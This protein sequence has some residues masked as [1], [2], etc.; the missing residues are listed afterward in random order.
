METGVQTSPSG[1]AAGLRLQLLGPV[2]AWHDGVPVAL[3]ASRKARA[4]IVYLAVAPRAVSRAHLCALLWDLPADPR[5]ELRWC[6]SKARG[7]LDQAGC[8]RLQSVGDAVQLDLRAAELDHAVLQAAWQEGIRG[9]DVRTLRRLAALWRGDFAEGLELARSPGFSAWLQAQRRQVR[10]A[11]TAVLEHLSAALAPDSDEGLA[12]LARWLQLAPFARRAHTLMVQALARR[13]QWQ[14]AE[15]HLHRAVQQFEAEGQDATAIVHAWRQAHAAPSA[16]QPEPAPA[17]VPAPWR[18]VALAVLPFAEALPAAGAAP[19]LSLGQA[20]AH[21]ITTRLA[22]LHSVFV[23]AA[24][25]SAALAAHGMDAEQAARALDVDYLASGTVQQ[26]PGRLRVQVQLSE[27][28]QGRIVWA[29]TLDAPAP[30]TLAVLG[31]LG[32]QLVGAIA[33][34]VELAERHRAILKPPELLDAWEAHHRGLWHMYRFHAQDNAQARHFFETAIRLDPSFSRPYAGLSFTHWQTAFLGW[35]PREAAS[36]LAYRSAVQGALA[37]AQDPT[38]RWALGRAHWLRGDIGPA[39]AELDMAVALSPSFS[40]GHYS[41]AFVQSQSGDAEAAI[42]ASDHARALSPFD[43]LLFAMLA[44]RA[45]ALLRL[46]RYDEAANWASRALVQPNAHV[47]IQGIAALCLALAER[48]DAA[49]RVVAAIRARVPGY[50][51]ADF[52]AAF[53]FDDEVQA[54]LRRTARQIGLG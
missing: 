15:Q 1:A 26:T 11:H 50:G 3:P 54:L 32:D 17:P 22:K 16:P 5:G 7:V 29:D 23:I 19:G 8:V 30:D 24:S 40:L 10:T 53:R 12:L 6:L 38:A 33:S 51:I 45:I 2:A 44:A 14:E 21:D 46:G 28:H 52:L 47:H 20:L 13:G 43:P 42:R 35:G 48:G 4:L 39:L 25:S 41:L 36:E 34:Q 49:R 27:A 31:A 9:Q 37:D 18:R